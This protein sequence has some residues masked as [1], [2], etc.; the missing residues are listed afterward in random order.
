MAKI[1]HVSVHMFKNVSSSVFSLEFISPS[2]NAQKSS[3]CF[4]T[5]AIMKTIHSGETPVISFHF[6]ELA[7]ERRL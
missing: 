3:S 6:A 2:V 5:A 7:L 1:T 4:L